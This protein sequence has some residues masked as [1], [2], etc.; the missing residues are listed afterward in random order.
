VGAEGA[1][2]V[3]MMDTYIIPNINVLLPYVYSPAIRRSGGLVVN[4]IVWNILVT[5]P[6]LHPFNLAAHTTQHPHL[7]VPT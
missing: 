2:L 7:A 1:V 3:E 6:F 5:D 4:D